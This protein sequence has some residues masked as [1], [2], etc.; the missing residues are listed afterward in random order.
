MNALSLALVGVMLAGVGSAALWAVERGVVTSATVDPTQLGAASDRATQATPTPVTSPT[1]GADS[2]TRSNRRESTPEPATRILPSQS[3]QQ[4]EAPRVQNPVAAPVRR[5]LPA[6]GDSP[7]RRDVPVRQ[8]APVPAAGPAR[9][10][11]PVRGALP[12][13]ENPTPEV[14]PDR[15]EVPARAAIAPSQPA[16]PTTALSSVREPIEFWVEWGG[17][18]PRSWFGT[19]RLDQGKIESA[20]G[21]GL[22]ADAPG[23]MFLENDVVTISPRVPRTFDS[24]LI[25]ATAPRDANLVV[26][27]IANGSTSGPF[28]ARIPL[29]TM[30]ESAQHRDL[31]DGGNKLIVRRTLGDRLRIE[32]DRGSLVFSPGEP[33]DFS[34]L[35]NPTNA[36]RQSQRCRVE[37]KVA[38]SGQRLWS[39]EQAAQALPD[40]TIASLG[41]FKVVM[42]QVEGVYDLVVS[43]VQTGDWRKLQVV[44]VQSKRIATNPTDAGSRGG[45]DRRFQIV[46][47]FDPARPLQP[48][49]VSKRA[50]FADQGAPPRIP[51]TH[52]IVRPVKRLN[53]DLLEIGANSWIALPLDATQPG[54]PHVLE[55]DYPNDALQTLGITIYEPGSDRPTV[56]TGLTTTPTNLK[57]SS[58]VATYRLTFWTRTAAPILVLSERDGKQPATVGAIRLAAAPI[59]LPELGADLPPAGRLVAAHLNTTM[60]PELFSATSAIDSQSGR[61]LR[62]WVTFFEGAQRLIQTLKHRGYN[63]AVIPVV[64]DGG[65]LYPSRLLEPTPRF[66]DGVFF[67]TSQDPMQKDV[68]EMLLRMFDR[69]GLQ[70]IPSVRFTGTLPILEAK[71]RLGEASSIN[72]V[73]TDGDRWRPSASSF[74]VG[75]HY[76]PLDEDVQSAMSSVMAELAGR[77]RSHASFAGLAIELANESYASLPGPDWGADDQ[78]L[79]RFMAVR[80][81]DA[82]SEPGAK[83]VRQ[84]WLSWRADRLSE[85]YAAMR[86]D[87]QAADRD[88]Q[89]YLLGAP[90][91]DSPLVT[92]AATTAQAPSGLTAAGSLLNF[93][94][95]V[96]SIRDGGI[97]FL[98][99]RQIKSVSPNSIDLDRAWDREL[100]KLFGPDEKVGT[101]D[102]VVTGS[103]LQYPP[104]TFDATSLANTS[105]VPNVVKTTR[106]VLAESGAVGL[107]GIAG[108]LA[109]V[110]SQAIFDG[111]WQTP[112]DERIW[113][114]TLL[115]YR[116]LPATRFET[117]SPP[118]GSKTQP[119]V[120]RRAVHHSQTYFYVVNDSPRPVGTTIG[121][122]GAPIEITSLNGT[123]MPPQET[124]ARGASFLLVLRPYQVVS[125]LVARPDAKIV[126]W[127]TLVDPQIVDE[128]RHDLARLKQC[129]GTNRAYPR[130]ANTDFDLPATRDEIPGWEFGKGAGMHV[131]VDTESTRNGPQALHLRSETPVNWATGP[132][133]W[134]RSGWIAPTPSGRLVFG[135]W[136]KTRDFEQQPHVR[137]VVEARLTNNQMIRRERVLGKPQDEPTAM[138]LGAD[139]NFYTVAFEGLPNNVKDIR[140]GID[141]RGT[142]DVW[143]DHVG[144]YDLWLNDAER[145]GLQRD[146]TIA[147]A[148]LDEGR[149]SD[150]EQLLNSHY[151]QYLFANFPEVAAPPKDV[152]IATT[153]TTST[154]TN[155]AI[156]G[157]SGPQRRPLPQTHS[158]RRPQQE[159]QTQSQ[160]QPKFE[161]VSRK[162]PSPP[163]DADVAPHAAPSAPRPLAVD[164]AVTATEPFMNFPM[165]KRSDDA[166]L[167]PNSITAAEPKAVYPRVAENP[168]EPPHSE[169]ERRRL[170]EAVKTLEKRLQTAR[171][172][173]PVDQ[174][175]PVGA[176]VRPAPEPRNLTSAATSA[177][178]VESATEAA[179]EPRTWFEKLKQFTLKPPER[180]PRS[181]SDR[182]SMFDWMKR[183]E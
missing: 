2:D 40:G 177:T 67:A 153:T 132:V 167:L 13:R 99:P 127:E 38:R 120:I 147:T 73:N 129:V 98:A 28:E 111:A 137:M 44:V 174:A 110:D 163:V 171:E 25:R 154:E 169:E 11:L 9:E 60:F 23:A 27:F 168:S 179:T 36:D 134:L 150:C 51:T 144:V 57:E 107:R 133:V 83:G 49:A 46:Q 79:E 32:T 114:D 149:I 5:D 162:A 139:W 182:R 6:P 33:F 101:R 21:Y 69:A 128:F 42:P 158:P 80:A 136:L 37:L 4:P 145:Q 77:C 117:V 141:L 93:G 106:T 81:A 172:R 75:T 135:G 55:I 170:A 31:D 124:D 71:R 119:V 18:E 22:Q 53:R 43:D 92:N 41:P 96:K 68:L 82:T 131:E 121:F 48:L 50:T 17:G 176:G 26:S 85:M 175:T 84:A 140:V 142:G 58:G 108:G 103:L 130:L 138:P 157:Q 56:D 19:L 116:Q 52:G 66:D 146:I 74:G 160:T 7:V 14:V 24:M 94:I 62:D 16:A 181:P 72:L 115:A 39:D 97:V 166:E 59:E 155:V 15:G 45:S 105:L 1:H 100:S 20:R 183:R 173:P 152:A 89:L 47:T 54:R 10:P 12:T 123:K 3:N 125:F 104:R 65:A 126:R 122:G 159:Q 112:R 165:M 88:A 164:D 109:S 87:I 151:T 90:L 113:N 161:P 35:P 102:E 34:V 95:D 91:L 178:P 64:S 143:I 63:G 118:V 70:L 180:R 29:S 8:A 30:L 76:N 156:N 61:A 148:M 86:R 78:T